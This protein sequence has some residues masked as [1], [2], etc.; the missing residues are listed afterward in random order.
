M[1]VKKRAVEG[2]AARKYLRYVRA[3]EGSPGWRSAQEVCW[4]PGWAGDV[5]GEIVWRDGGRGWVADG[6][7][8]G[9]VNGLEMSVMRRHSAS[10]SVLTAS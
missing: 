1:R 6:K 7:R 2:K 3:Q 10:R 8:I 4:I 5:I 9:D